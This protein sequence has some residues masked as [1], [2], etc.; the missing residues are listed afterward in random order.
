M[1]HPKT[2]RA[3]RRTASPIPRTVEPTNEQFPS[4]IESN[5]V[6]IK[7][8]AVSLNYRDIGML[9]GRYPINAQECGIPASDCAGEVF[10]FGSNVTEFQIGDRVSPC[11]NISDWDG[12]QR[13]GV[14]RT[15]GA[16]IGVLAEYVVMDANLL[17]HVPKYLSWEEV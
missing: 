10:S 16:D 6:I 13:D 8:R 3:Y 2:F 17:V 1:N 12:K 11:F 4:E 15:L 14:S 5:E 9:N 7:I